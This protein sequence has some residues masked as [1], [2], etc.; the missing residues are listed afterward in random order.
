[1]SLV[2]E[3]RS[4]IFLALLIFLSGQI[5]GEVAILLSIPYFVLLVI[6]I[7]KSAKG[8]NKPSA[9][10]NAFLIATS[11]ILLLL[12]IWGNHRSIGVDENGIPFPSHSHF[13][14]KVGHVH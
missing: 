4:I 10:A 6:K 3:Y 2:K 8:G 1:M 9:Y 12:P 11:A 13:L 5:L 7:V 14:W